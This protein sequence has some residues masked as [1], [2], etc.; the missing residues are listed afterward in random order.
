MSDPLALMALAAAAGGGSIDGLE[1]R[2]LVA[3]GLTML[4]RC[5]PLVR[6]LAP[7]RGAILLP[8][9]A[10]YIVA[11]AACEGRG[12]VLLDPGASVDEI[13]RTIEE[14]GARVVFTVAAQAQ[15]IPGPVAR[16]LLDE[17]PGHAIFAH[18][19]ERRLVDL[20][21]HFGL[22]IEG[23]GNTEGR[24]EEAVVVRAGTAAV[25]MRSF[26]HRELLDSARGA[27]EREE[28]GSSDSVLALLPFHRPLGLTAALLAPL[29]AGARVATMPHFDGA[30]AVDL[31]ER[32]GITAA[33][34]NGARFATM[35]S[36]LRQRGRALDA[37]ALRAVIAIGEPV[38][39]ETRAEWMEATGLELRVLDTQP[40]RG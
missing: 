31:I 14:A 37:P 4:Q 19:T 20:G 18:G 40:E 17:L 33:V 15:A 21:S 35:A 34:G 27:L 10:A 11:L 6:A 30:T 32:G 38:A 28:L 26:T 12:A 23:E 1:A 36:A 22:E 25:G 3:A 13:A 9:S 5:A 7:G 29:L 39:S 8:D 2:Q 16:V 24:D